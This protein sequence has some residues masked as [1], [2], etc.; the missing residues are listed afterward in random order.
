MFNSFL[1]QNDL[2]DWLPVEADF[3]LCDA[4]ERVGQ[5]SDS[6]LK[7]WVDREQGEGKRRSQLKASSSEKMN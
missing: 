1:S 2:I 5:R 7:G 3:S 4:L 6:E